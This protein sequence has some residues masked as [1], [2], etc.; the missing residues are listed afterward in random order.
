MKTE[1]KFKCNKC[2]SGIVVLV[3]KESA[4]TIEMQVKNCNNCK[5]S[6]GFKGLLKLTEVIPKP[7]QN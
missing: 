7:T 3:T 1:K 6:F 5:A 4:K 2:E